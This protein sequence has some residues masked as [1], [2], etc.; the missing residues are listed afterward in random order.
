[1]LLEFLLVSIFINGA[2][3]AIAAAMK[4]DRVTD[5]S[6]SLT[7]VVLAIFAVLR[8]PAAPTV[9]QLVVA[10]LVVIWGFR[11]GGYLLVRIMRT[12]VDHRFDAMRD[13]PLVFA[14]F[15]ALQA[16]TVWIVMLPLALALPTARAG[17]PWCLLGCLVW[18][19]GL[20]LEARSDAE[21]YRFRNDP[22]N[23]KRPVDCGLWRYSRHP[24]YF[25]EMLV[26]WGLWL[27]LLPA[28]GDRPAIALVAALG[29]LF[30]TLLL[31]FV[32]GI[33]LLERQSAA[34]Y[35]KAWTEY[36]K[37]TSLLVPRPPRR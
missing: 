13:K 32:S 11:L 19:A 17:M 14:R 16:L 7:F 24:N 6:Y 26:W 9:W 23:K 29:P 18:L 35:G 34:R 25:G 33:P 1:M 2:F 31:L 27:A 5:L 28:W 10:G 37:R 21:K 20:Y 8:L 12:G 30:L 15:W 4:T 3:F 22:A 36:A